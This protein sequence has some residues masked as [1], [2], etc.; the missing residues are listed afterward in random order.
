MTAG[1]DGMTVRFGVLGAITVWRGGEPVDVGHARQRWVLGALLADAGDVVPAHVLV[2]RVWGERAPGRGRD[3]VY[4]YVS[5]L[6]HVLSGT[7]TDI[8]R[9]QGG[10]RLGAP[11]GSVDVHR[12]RDLTGRAREAPDAERAATSWEEALA[13]W[14][15]PAY[16]GADTPWFNA[17]RD[18]LERERL[19]ARLD[20]AEVRLRLGQHDR[21]LAELFARAEDHPL[22]ERAAGQLILAL[23]R[24]GRSADALTRYQETRRRL[25]EELGTDPGPA[26]RR[27]H[28]Q[29][30]TADPAL[31]LAPAAATVSA[32]RA[33]R[34][35][36][37]QLPAPPGA[38]VGRR[39]E[40][41]ELDALLKEPDGDETVLVISAIGGA[42]GMGKTWLALRWAHENLG[43]FPDG[44]LYASLCG[45]APSA[46]P[47]PPETVLRG[48]LDALGTEPGN[49]P[50]EPDGQAGLF[51]SLTADRRML[52]VL[53]DARDADQVR[54]LL[55]GGATCTVVVTSRSHL[56][57]L[58]ATHG[59][60]Y[61]ALDT[62][63]DEDAQQ[64]LTRAV[65][66]D[67]VAAEPGAVTALFRR[68]A[69]LPL[70]LSVVAARAAT[71]P[72]FPLAVLAGEL[73]DTTGLDALNAGDLATDL[74]AV[75]ATSYRTL[76]DRTAEVFALLGLAPGPDIGIDAAA[77]LT[78]LPVHRVR[79]AL[80]TLEAAHL[81]QQQ[82]PGRYRMHDLVRLYAAERGRERPA[83]VRDGALRRVLDFY[84]GTALAGDRLAA[85]HRT[86]LAPCGDGAG[87]D[88]VPLRDAD[89]AL[90]W[91]EA[92][93]ACLLAVH[94]FALTHGRHRPAWQLAWALDTF[95]WRRGRLPDRIAVLGATLPALRTL[96]DPASLALAHRLLA[97][98]HVP[99]G[100]HVRALEHL[101]RAVELY[102]EAGD[103]AGQAQ[104]HLNFAL[105][106]EA[107]GDHGQALA[108]A[109]ENL[110]IRTTLRS[111]AR[112][113]EAL[114]AVGW[115]HAHLG[116][117]G[118]A[119]D[120]CE[121]ALV[122]CRRHDLLETEAFTL[123]SLGYTAHHSGR[124]A[125]A[126]DHYGQALALRR[127]LGDR[128][129]EADALARLGHAYQALSRF[130]EAHRAWSLA[131]GLYR[132]QRR[133]TEALGVQQHLAVLEQRS[134]RPWARASGPA[135]LAGP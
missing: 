82:T 20:L 78:A 89:A 15:G 19:A 38:F 4:G 42:G 58:N 40:L 115:Y 25:G 65:G 51:R 31:D 61:L 94:H 69:G 135:W 90:S 18:F 37:R 43:R 32:T 121:R 117:H 63:R 72:G 23:H 17:R 68:C 45:F 93:H 101:R 5:R 105:A 3:A 26:L 60:R 112:E 6:R 64:I 24:S 102:E 88:P 109:E 98:T 12:F 114:N 74:R 100:R 108:H 33:A 76:D 59:C 111:P 92:E 126:V 16:E 8:V 55:P 84:V 125:L 27:L 99:F 83:D 11:A 70:A 56:G 39:R 52:I 50:A 95:H 91:F 87:T 47:T 77:R 134:E 110:R 21:M 9:T 46:R 62:L 41:A 122:L 133:T 124:Y 1:G 85:P 120:Y 103:A 22:D 2:D 113:A 28:Q 49:M 57:G 53:D 44:Q 130:A 73:D 13:L 119:R 127:H 80:R 81:V 104:T 131:L 36:P 29:V 7:G 14:R 129:E 116:H 107:R 106:W 97:R 34:P 35:V 48:F 10:Y 86:P 30:L 67:R 75:F 128:F 54:P 96:G 123:D 118:Q 79:A 66:H 71:R 132:D